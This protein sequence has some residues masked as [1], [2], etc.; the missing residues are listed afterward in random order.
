MVLSG[1]VSR[2]TLLRLTIKPAVLEKMGGKATAKRAGIL[3]QDCRDA[4]D[5]GG[6]QTEERQLP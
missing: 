1:L 2:G 5:E 4:E 6:G 3:P